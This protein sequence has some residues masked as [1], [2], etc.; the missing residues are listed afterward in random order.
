MIN[1]VAPVQAL[2]PVE[3]AIV[4]SM[5]QYSRDQ[6]VQVGRFMADNNSPDSVFERVKFP[7]QPDLPLLSQIRDTTTTSE[8]TDII[9]YGTFNQIF[10]W[11]SSQNRDPDFFH[12]ALRVL[13]GFIRRAEPA[14][15][16]LVV[17]MLITAFLNDPKLQL[18]DEIYDAIMSHIAADYHLSGALAP[19]FRALAA[20][21]MA[22]QLTKRNEF[23]GICRDLVNASRPFILLTGRGSF[24]SLFPC[25]IEVL[26]RRAVEFLC[27]VGALRIPISS[28]VQTCFE[29][30]PRAILAFVEASDPLHAYF[31]PDETPPLVLA[32]PT[33]D[34]RFLTGSRMTFNASLVCPSELVET[35]AVG[36]IL[37]LLPDRFKSSILQR[38][39]KLLK[40]VNRR[41]LDAF[42]RVFGDLM[43]SLTHSKF[44]FDMFAIYLYFSSNLSQKVGYSKILFSPNVFHRDY[45]GLGSSPIRL[46]SSETSSSRCA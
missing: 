5:E 40:K 2:T 17:C 7:I 12:T 13:N 20:R 36:S 46:R 21:V 22:S 6:L 41:Y 30:L 4:F 25:H 18:T 44:C 28:E 39:P 8:L 26:D 9:V 38:L 1:G 23:L 27:F 42:L 43:S 11:I 15:I 32:P 14:E 10:A 3:R 37:D 31:R 29:V 34:C 24:M 16:D 45:S 35:K 33:L 19:T